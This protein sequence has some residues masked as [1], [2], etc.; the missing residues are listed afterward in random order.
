MSSLRNDVSQLTVWSYSR[1]HMLEVDNSF[2]RPLRM[3]IIKCWNSNPSPSSGDEM[4]ENLLG[5]QPGDSKCFGCE[6]KP[7]SRKSCASRSSTSFLQAREVE[8]AK[9]LT[10]QQRFELEEAKRMIEEQRRTSELHTQQMEEMKKM[11]EEMSRA[12]RGP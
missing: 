4:C 1:K 5:R 6:R 2:R 8:K 10:E 7:K 3:C 11:I 9:V 12:H